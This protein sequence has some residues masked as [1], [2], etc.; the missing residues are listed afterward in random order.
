MW[1]TSELSLMIV[2]HV[3][4]HNHALGSDFGDVRIGVLGA[5]LMWLTEY[6]DEWPTMWWI[7]KTPMLQSTGTDWICTNCFECHIMNSW[8]DWRSQLCTHSFKGIVQIMMMSL[9]QSKQ[10][11]PNKCSLLYCMCVQNFIVL[12]YLKSIHKKTGWH[13]ASSTW[14]LTQSHQTA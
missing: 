14:T 10:S 8:R 5:G 2:T 9:S 12:L 6:F 13:V 4:P 3:Y 1:N 7:R 11:D